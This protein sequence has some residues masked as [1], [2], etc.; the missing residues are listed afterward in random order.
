MA[1]YFTAM[2]LSLSKP[3]CFFDLETTGVQ[4]AKDRIVEIAILK[5]FP[6]GEERSKTWRVNPGIP[7]PPEVT[8][9][10]GISDKDVAECPTFNEL[11]N[12]I[13][14]WI[15]DADLSGYNA[16]RFD[17]PILAEEF[18]RAEKKIDFSKVKCVDV[19]NIFHKMEQRTLLAAYRFYCDKDLENAHS[20]EADTLATYE[21]LKAQ[22]DKYPELE[23]N[24]DWL[25]KFSE[26]KR[27][28]ADFAGFLQFN[29]K[30]QEMFGFGK[31]KGR[32]VE[33]ILEENPGYFSWLMDADFPR[34]TKQVLTKIRLRKFGNK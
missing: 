15:K 32:L 34:Y 30:N 28:P 29:D 13:Y 16:L 26:S 11:A 20:A 18:L 21:V 12:E 1:F 27:R 25:A 17:I 33:E 19:Q 24:M 8:A 2:E 14:Q 3:I 31:Y 6:D 4:I 22:L 5:V 9:I 10:H 23:N 7:I